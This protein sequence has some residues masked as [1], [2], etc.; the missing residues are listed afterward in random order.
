[1][2]GLWIALIA[3]ACGCAQ[4]FSRRPAPVKL[5]ERIK[6]IAIRLVVNKTQQFGLEDALTTS[7]RDNFLRDGSY[8]L[9]PEEKADGIVVA[10]LQ[11]YTLTPVQYDSTLAPT[12]Y[13]L[14]VACDLQLLDN[15]DKKVLGEE[16]DMEGVQIYAASTMTGG[17]TETQAQ[18]QIWDILSRDIV[19]RV[20]QG[21]VPIPPAKTAQPR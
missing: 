13:K 2:K 18:A 21:F 14:K 19:K 4:G 11:R 5:P 7:I 17:L 15:A 3:A 16:K 12:A 1:M 9:V 20:T 6:S 10:T 8:P